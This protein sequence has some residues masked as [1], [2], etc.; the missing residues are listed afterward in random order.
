MIPPTVEKQPFAPYT[1]TRSQ[2][3]LNKP[4]PAM[5]FEMEEPEYSG[6]WTDSDDEE[7]EEEE[8]DD[9]DHSSAVD[10][11]ASPSESR[12][13]TESYPIFVSSGSDDFDLVDHSAPTDPLDTIVAPQRLLPPRTDSFESNTSALT[14]KSEAQ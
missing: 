8:D 11:I 10:S 3:F 1:P 9:D 13:S 6:M 7:E 2:L 12:H 5:P 4:L 14:S